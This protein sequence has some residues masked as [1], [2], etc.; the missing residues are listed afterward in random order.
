ML[1]R[2]SILFLFLILIFG[3]SKIKITQLGSF[4]VKKWDSS[5]LKDRI[6]C[7]DPGHGGTAGVDNF[8]VG[9]NGERE[10]WINLRVALILKGMLEEVGAKVI[11]TR[12]QD[13]EVDLAYRANKAIGNY[14][15]IFVSIHHNGTMDRDV[16]YP[17]VFFHSK[18]SENPA[19][20]D[21]AKILLKNFKKSLNFKHMMKGFNLDDAG[22]YSDHLIYDVGFAVIRKTYPYMPGVIGE[23]AFFSN[24]IQEK[25]LKEEKYN[26][27][28]AQAYFDAL[29]EYFS[30]GLPFAELV[31][32][33]KNSEVANKISTVLL[34][35]D[36]GFGE[37]FFD[38]DSFEV[39]VNG[40][41]A[42][43]S[44]DP[45]TG[46]LIIKFDEPLE[47]KEYSVFVTARNLKGNSIHPRELKFKV[48]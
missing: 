27:L 23:A 5:V 28:E 46:H 37:H 6:I 11:M 25:L 4:E 15:D 45:L 42:D 3:C 12:M 31:S 33:E 8:R 19:S 43:Y 1:K 17:L 7:L 41:S 9:L 47:P 29:V 14:A 16:D 22:I 39:K 18:A 20:V 40:M 35:L 44:F 34:K 30:K 24:P 13:V 10:E 36:D 48:L 38:L 32:P 21:F 2:L 26:R